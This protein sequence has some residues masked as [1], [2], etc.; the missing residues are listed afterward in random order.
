M[1]VGALIK[2]R[3]SEQ[4]ICFIHINKRRNVTVAISITNGDVLSGFLVLKNPLCDS[5]GILIGNDEQYFA[6]SIDC[7]FEKS[8]EWLNDD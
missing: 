2:V 7:A 5:N 1:Q 6:K 3:D 8:A 4:C